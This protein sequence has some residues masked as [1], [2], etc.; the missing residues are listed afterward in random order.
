MVQKEKGSNRQNIL[1]L[2]QSEWRALHSE[3]V[4]LECVKEMG[5]LYCGKQQLYLIIILTYHF[6]SQMRLFL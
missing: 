5:L 4:R 1:G 6:F 3:G 2:L